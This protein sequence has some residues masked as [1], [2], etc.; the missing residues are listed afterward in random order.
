MVGQRA[1]R[2][3]RTGLPS[4]TARPLPQQGFL[5]LCQ[6]VHPQEVAVDARLSDREGTP[7]SIVGCACVPLPR[8]YCGGGGAFLL[9]RS[10]SARKSTSSKCRC[11]RR[12]H[13][14][15]RDAWAST[16]CEPRPQNHTARRYATPYVAPRRPALRE[17]RGKPTHGCLFNR[18]QVRE[19]RCGAYRV[20]ERG[21][22]GS[23]M[24]ATKQSELR[25]GEL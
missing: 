8:G 19:E 4:V 5:A 2:V 18:A 14:Y 24:Q 23:E 20:K 25:M 11:I 13:S 17:G 15:V 16:R 9:K 3:T 1:P 7:A 6:S 21:R 10:S 12:S 22:R